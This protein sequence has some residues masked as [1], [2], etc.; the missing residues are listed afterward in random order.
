MVYGVIWS[1]RHHEICV[2]DVNNLQQDTTDVTII[3]DDITYSHTY[4][5]PSHW[6]GYTIISWDDFKAKY[7]ID[8]EYLYRKR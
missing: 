4:S 7:D 5:P 3:T 6:S 8:I 1:G 2:F